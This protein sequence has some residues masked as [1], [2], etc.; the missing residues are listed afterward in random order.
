M[1]S[2]SIIPSTDLFAVSWFKTTSEEEV[3]KLTAAA[4]QLLSSA[5]DALHGEDISH[6]QIPS[7]EKFG[8]GLSANVGSELDFQPENTTSD[9]MEPDED[10]HEETC[11]ED[12]ETKVNQSSKVIAHHFMIYFQF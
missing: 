1:N 11:L 2:L 12:I 10:Q 7:L 9:V 3:S 6:L 4:C 8:N 5:K